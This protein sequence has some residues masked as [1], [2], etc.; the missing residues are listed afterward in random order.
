V[1]SGILVK[2]VQCST[3]PA[4][5]AISWF[6]LEDY[7]PSI[8]ESFANAM[9]AKERAIV[10]ARRNAVVEEAAERFHKLTSEEPAVV[11]GVKT[12]FPGKELLEQRREQGKLFVFGNY[13]IELG[14]D[15]RRIPFGIIYGVYLGEIVQRLGRIGRGDVDQAEVVLPVPSSY[16]STAKRFVEEHGGRVSYGEFIELLRWIMPVKLGV[17]AFGTEFITEHK[18]GKLR[19]YTP[20]ATYVLTL[21]ALWEYVEELRTLCQ[22]FVEVADT[23]EILSIFPWLR[24][25]S[26]SAS[27]LVPIASFRIT[28]SVP[29]VRD[30]IED[31]ASLSTL[32]GN[33]DVEYIDGKLVIRG[34]SK[35]SLK[36]ILCLKCSYLPYSL[37]DTVMPSNL[38]L[39]LIKNCIS[40]DSRRSV[41]YKVLKDYP[42]PIYIAEPMAKSDK[43]EVYQVFNAF[44]YAVRVDLTLG[45]VAFYLLL[46]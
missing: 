35:K 34:A 28:T 4:S 19:V 9:K 13:S 12:L 45:G 41:L 38:L 25:V 36:D 3:E 27:V 26:K 21:V 6:K 46:L 39:A 40:E 16:E 20:L 17:E 15:L 23:L 44:G 30:G 10:F 18:L 1:K 14:I 31:Y 22:E 42:I 29:Y 32:L 11:T 5:G 8:V 2:F 7:I 33:Y 24:K 37:F 43:G